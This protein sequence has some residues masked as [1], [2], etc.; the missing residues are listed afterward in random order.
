MLEGDPEYISFLRERLS[1]FVFLRG[2]KAVVTMAGDRAEHFFIEGA[3]PRGAVLI[4]RDTEIRIKQPEVLAPAESG[5]TYEDIGGLSQEL[6]L[7]R[8]VIELPLKYPFVFQQLG[9]EAPKGIL[10]YGP[11]GTGK[12]LIARA[13]ASENDTH[14]IHVNGP[15]IMHKY[16]GES[17][18]RLREVFAEAQRNAPSIIFLD[19]IDALAPRRTEV[20]GDVEKRVVGQLLALMDGLESR[21]KVIVLGATNLPELIDPALRR[22]GRFDREI[23]ISVPDREG[24]LEILK[25]H[26]RGMNINRDVDLEDLARVTHGFV[27]AD[28]AALCREAGMC[29]LRRSLPELR[30]APEGN[31]PLVVEARDFR[32]A[33]AKVEPSATR[34]FIVEI[35]DVSWEDVGGLDDIRTRLERLVEWP[36]KYGDLFRQFRLNNPSGILLSGPPGTGKTLVVQALARHSGLNFISIGGAALCSRWAGEAERV[37]HA[38]FR[39]ARQ[40]APCLLFLDEIDTIAPARGTGDG[41]R[42][43]L[44]RLLSQL[45]LE[46]GG[47]ESLGEV[48]VIA[49]TNRPDR[50]DPALLRGGRFD[51]VIEFP[52]PDSRRR[53]EIFRACLR[54][55]PTEAGISFP[56]LAQDTEGLVGADIAAICRRAALL[57]LTEVVEQEGR[58]DTLPAETVIREKH[59]RLALAERR[60]QRKPQGSG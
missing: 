37:L 56:E 51:E 20:H 29:C 21:G 26:T 8:E 3:N 17:E 13:V 39:K 33:L 49:A 7:V 1:G 18:A 44:E 2:D 9:I 15:E 24:R 52:V 32:E 27:G 43:S 38:V 5:T 6:R 54:L 11:P 35:P 25:I 59:L 40:V 34:E 45:L 53:E 14:F 42:H 31:L 12:T 36:L 30:R 4:T 46:L 19:E 55:K 50:L 60:R 28:L 41:P 48:V 58:R 47:L 57:A 23:A 10:L 22:P 16:Y